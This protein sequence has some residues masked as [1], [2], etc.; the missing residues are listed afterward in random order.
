MLWLSM[1]LLGAG[2]GLLLA[3]DSP[4]LPKLR[5]VRTR[6]SRHLAASSN[7]L[8]LPHLATGAGSLLALRSGL[9]LDQHLLPPP[10]RLLPPS[11]LEDSRRCLG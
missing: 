8:S 4:K 11:S 9:G 5:A 7:P 2:D 3:S 6:P 1:L 10:L